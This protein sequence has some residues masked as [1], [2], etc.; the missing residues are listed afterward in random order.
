MLRS[1][2]RSSVL[3]VSVKFSKEGQDHGFDPSFRILSFK[4]SLAH[5]VSEAVL[6]VG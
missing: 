4:N 1:C 5:C 6:K 2:A 3:K